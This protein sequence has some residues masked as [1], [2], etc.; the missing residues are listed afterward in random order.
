MLF[1]CLRRGSCGPCVTQAEVATPLEGMGKLWRCPCDTITAECLGCGVWLPPPRFQRTP[2]RRAGEGPLAKPSGK[3][4]LEPWRPPPAWDWKG[5]R[6]DL[7]PSGFRGRTSAT[8]AW[9]PEPQDREHYSGALRC[10]A[11][12]PIGLGLAGDPSCLS[13]LPLLPFGKGV[14]M[15]CLCPT[16]VFWKHISCLISQ[17]HTWRGTYLRIKCTL[18]LTIS[19][20]DDI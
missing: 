20:L 2:R 6:Q 1:C 5:W 14:S 17:V 8:G 13:P 10:A 3:G 18:R 11:V 16:F 7:H 15:L 19:D 9:K 4:L 12:C